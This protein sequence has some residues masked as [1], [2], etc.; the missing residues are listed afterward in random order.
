MIKV[1]LIPTKKRK[2][3]KPV[4]TFLIVGA[5][6]LLFSGIALA[7]VNVYF[8]SKIETLNTR[9]AEQDKKIA[10][11]NKKIEGVKDFEKIK[12][13]FI[14][15]INIIEKLRK[16]QNIPV[17]I[18]DEI[19]ARLTEGIW[20]TSM[21]ITGSNINM[22]GIG[23]SNPEIVSFVQSLKA[24]SLFKEVYLV[25]T[26]KAA[27]ENVETYVFKITFLAQIN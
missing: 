5:I 13:T 18:L 23:F 12:Q 7:Y 24:S 17:I 1:N 4:P 3:P 25:E 11:L 27:M 26:R 22:D 14:D 15:R 6:L 21:T 16:N 10:E 8:G 9:I 19:S 2:K 20:L